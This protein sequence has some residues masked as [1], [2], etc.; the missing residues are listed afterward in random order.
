VQSRNPTLFLQWGWEHPPKVDAFSNG[1][2]A[3]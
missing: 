2:V 1:R 3:P